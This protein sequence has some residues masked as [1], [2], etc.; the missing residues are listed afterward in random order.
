MTKGFYDDDI[1]IAPDKV[2]QLFKKENPVADDNIDMFFRERKLGNTQKARQFGIDMV[3]ELKD[4]VW[5]SAP[6][7]VNPKD[8]EFQLKT[9]FAYAVHRI[10]EDYSPNQIV[11]NAAVS[12]FYENL[13]SENYELFQK[14]TQSPAISLYLYM[15][16]S[17]EET[18]ENIGKTFAGLCSTTLDEQC[19]T[20][21]ETAYAR[22][23]G[24]IANKLAS[25]GFVER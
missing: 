4:C 13:E 17:G 15:H 20:I 1:K 9:L 23:V 16:R 24:S 3:Q 18:P 22:F 25:V 5:T 12:S 6:D 10:L 11:A 2:S 8:F 14:I 19:R 21:G 7:M